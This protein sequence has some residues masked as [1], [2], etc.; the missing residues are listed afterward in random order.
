[1]R[2]KCGSTNR[3]RPSTAG[4][5]GL[6]DIRQ[7][8][9][10]AST[11]LVPGGTAF[12]EIGHQHADAVA[13]LVSGFRSLNLKEIANDLQ[14]I[15]R[16]AV[17]ERR[18]TDSMSSCLFCKI[19]AGEIPAS[20]VY[21]DDRMIAFNDINPQAPMHVL[22]VPKKHLAT[23]NDLHR[24]RTIWL[25][26]WCGPAPRSRRNAATTALASGR[27]STATPRQVRRCFTSTCTS[28][29]AAS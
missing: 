6:R 16:V 1:M 2:P 21:E 28:S 10:I 23:L 24:R 9:D 7:I 18:I 27:S 17:I 19:I 5:D 14:C 29:A 20:K 25:A 15:P 4:E 13:E 11:Q 8:I 22:V 3:L 12:I 26:R